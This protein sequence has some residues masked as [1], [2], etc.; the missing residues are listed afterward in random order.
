MRPG[1]KETREL[2]HIL[3]IARYRLDLPRYGSTVHQAHT[4]NDNS[5]W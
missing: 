3:I 2:Y 1:F 4:E 5:T